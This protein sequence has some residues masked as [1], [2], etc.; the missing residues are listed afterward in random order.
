MVY[1]AGAM[2]HHICIVNNTATYAE[3]NIANVVD[4]LTLL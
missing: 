4:A 3:Q 1:S 2:K